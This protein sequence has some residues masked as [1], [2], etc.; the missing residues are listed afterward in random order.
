[1]VAD[2]HCTNLNKIAFR[3]CNTPVVVQASHCVDVRDW[4][5]VELL[6][7]HRVGVGGVAEKED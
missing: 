7:Q 6:Q 3:T 4:E 5:P 2:A 1:M